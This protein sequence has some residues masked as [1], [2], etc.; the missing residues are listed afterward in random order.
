MGSWIK[1]WGCW[2]V[3]GVDGLGGSGCQVWVLA[4]R[5]WEFRCGVW[6]G[7]G[8]GGLGVFPPC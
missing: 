8:F 1:V 4:F 2:M 6:H 3:E 5:D 7:L